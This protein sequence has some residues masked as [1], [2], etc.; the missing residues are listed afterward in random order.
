MGGWDHIKEILISD[1]YHDDQGKRGIQWDR[2]QIR[3]SERGSGPLKKKRLKNER[4]HCD[5][6]E[7]RN[8]MG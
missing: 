1:R 2:L 4:Y 3:V 8:P 5:Q 7:E 6:G